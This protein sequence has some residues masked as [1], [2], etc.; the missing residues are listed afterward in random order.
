[1]PESQAIS[2]YILHKDKPHFSAIFDSH[3]LNLAS[4]IVPLLSS[5]RKMIIVTLYAAICCNFSLVIAVLLSA[6]FAITGFGTVFSCL[7]WIG[8]KS[9]L[10]DFTPAFNHSGSAVR[11]LVP[12]TDTAFIGAVFFS[13][14]WDSAVWTKILISLKKGFY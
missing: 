5:L 13:Y 1:M 9:F 7:A 3:F 10:T 8:K 2:R 12:P 4:V 6:G 11:M 14:Q